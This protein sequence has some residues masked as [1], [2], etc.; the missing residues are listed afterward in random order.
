MTAAVPLCVDLDG[1]LVRVDLLHEGLLQAVKRGPSEVLGLLGALTKGKAPF[2]HKVAALCAVDAS[3]LPYRAEVIALI[4]E[5]RAAGRPVILC[6]ASPAPFARSVAEHLGLFDQVVTSTP[7]LNLATHAKADALAQSYGE[8]GF[9]YIGNCDHDLAVF[10]RARSGILVCSQPHLRARARAVQPNMIF[11]D[12]PRPPA[13][14]WIK[15]FRVHQWVKNLLVFVPLAAGH[16][17]GDPQ[18]LLNAILAFMAFCFC[19][20]ALYICNDLLDLNADR[21]H[22]SKRRRPFAAGTISVK[23][24]LAAVAGLLF[25]ALMLAL[26]LP[27]RFGAILLGYAFI[28]TAYS[29]RLKQ[30][31]VVDVLLLAGLYTIRIIAGAAATVIT[32]SFWLLGFSMFIFLCLAMVKRVSELQRTTGGGQLAGRGYVQEDRIVLIALGASSGMVA[33]LILALYMQSDTMLR[34]Y[35]A[36]GWLWLVPPLVLYWITRLWLKTNRNE[37]E[38]DPVVFAI[39]D[40]QSLALLGLIGTIFLLATFGPALW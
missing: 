20:S 18:R 3:S 2:K 37:I 1:T 15:A 38:D 33:V 19:A 22:H 40:W 4:E 30:Q 32:P 14:A 28:T 29:V 27:W 35:P 12:D 7:D 24:A 16:A 17:M 34:M 23:A 31:V 6:T 9:D 10:A 36:G 13:K 8:N 39:R 25:L 11:I 26:L 21:A 5:A